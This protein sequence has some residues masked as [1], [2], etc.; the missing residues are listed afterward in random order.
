MKIIADAQVRS[1]WDDIC[2]TKEEATFRKAQSAILIQIGDA[3]RQLGLSRRRVK[4]RLA[5]LDL[6]ADQVTRVAK[7]SF[8]DLSLEQLR[9]CLAV[10]E[11]K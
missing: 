4:K 2:D 1:V 5:G 6:P 11:K 9:A 10:I 3:R 8:A 7:G